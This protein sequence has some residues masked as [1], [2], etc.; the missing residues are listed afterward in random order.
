VIE[1]P[2]KT[3]STG[4]AV[5]A[6]KLF[7]RDLRTYRAML[8]ARRVDEA[9]AQFIRNR[10]AFF[11]VSGAGHE[12]SAVLAE[13]LSPSDWL[14]L[15]Y[16][17]KA[18]M[19]ARGIPPVMF[20]HS[21][22]CSAES[23]S[24]GRQMS[25]HMSDPALHILSLVG[26]V[27]NNALQ[28]VGVAAEVSAPVDSPIVVCSVGDGTSQQG[29]FMEAVAEAVREQL[30]VLFVIEDNAYAISTETSRKTWYSLRDGDPDEFYGLPIHRIDG[31]SPERCGEPLQACVTQLRSGC[32]P[33][34]VVMS[35]DRL[36]SHTNAD[37]EHVYRSHGE[38]GRVREEGDPLV[39][40]RRHL[41]ASGVSVARLDALERETAA[42][43]E[44]ARESVLRATAPSTNVALIDAPC[45]KPEARGRGEP[46]A[47]MSRAIRDVLG[48]HLMS[49]P[50][51]TLFGQDIEDP[52]GDV[53]GVTKGL[54][55][56]FKGRVVNSPLSESTIVGKAIG[57]A[58]AG[59][60]PVACIQF[61]DFLPLAFN[62]II[63][64]LG[65]MV[66]RTNG[67]WNC[68]V[69]IM[70]PCGGYRP[71]LGPFH[72]QTM[73]S[74]LSHVPDVQ[75][76]MPSNATDAAGLL[77]AAFESPRPTIFLYPKVCL[78][79]RDRTT[80]ADVS[81]QFVPLGRSRHLCRGDDLSIVTYG[82]TTYQC[83]QAAEALE[84]HGV[85]VDL[86]DLRS[87]KPWDT[88]AVIESAKRTGRL[89]VVH[90]DNGSCSVASEIVATVTESIT[91]PIQVRR[92]TRSDTYIP[93]D[94]GSQLE[95][96]PSFKRVLETATDL[97]GMEVGW[98]SESCPDGSVINIEAQGGSP[99]D[100]A[101]TLIEWRVKPGEVVRDGQV[102]VEL[103]AD[104][105]MFEYSSPYDAMVEELL[106]EPGV[107]VGVGTPI[108]RLR[109]ID[110]ERL[111]RVT[112]REESGRPVLKGRPTPAKMVR[113]AFAPA[114]VA[115]TM[116]VSVEGER[117]LTNEQIVNGFSERSAEEIFRLTGIHSRRWVGATQT[118][119][120]LAVDACDLALRREGLTISDINALVVSTTTPLS[121]TPS[122]ACLVLGELSSGEHEIPAHD[123]SAACTGYLY[124]LA[125]GY[126]FIQGR[127]DAR[128][129]VVTTEVLSPLLDPN[130]FDTAILFADA[131]TATILGGS[132]GQG[133]HLG[134]LHRP[135]LFSRP[136]TQGALRVGFRDRRAS[137]RSNGNG[138]PKHPA[139]VV[140]MDHGKRV[141]AQAVR[142]MDRALARA[143]DAAGYAPSD[144]SIV[145]PHQANGRIIDAVSG[146]LGSDCQVINA[147]AQSGNTS[148][149]SIPLAM[150]E[151]H[152]D[153]AATIGLCAFGGGFTYGAAIIEARR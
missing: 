10:Q 54:S 64:E 12:A 91:T 110:P 68:P 13:L 123:V 61:A 80:P 127:Q 109:L 7:S 77:N 113:Q 82:G 52:K 17:D 11:H 98:L 22:L 153:D 55:N 35:V 139:L 67:G 19:L 140:E 69:I 108:L 81:A 5:D 106:V 31:R 117:V 83:I 62:Q 137:Q 42:A 151:M 105:A 36:S 125:A 16:R 148:S 103:E 135:L 27:G 41:L 56:E 143:S 90:E 84:E 142:S 60:R 2:N 50:R 112:I 43:V 18:L 47:T 49:D 122:M 133:K 1:V 119:L 70:A 37:D 38:L 9:E 63:S 92:V 150:R 48:H 111:R 79:D 144:L 129:L 134:Q 136:D 104:K 32:G 71:G 53:F 89:I 8:L 124:A 141:F 15:H 95:V 118:A 101:V 100:Q 97:L 73:E 30:P 74:I 76:V 65:S 147:I 40:F 120:T 78:N 59:G 66:W 3:G 25:A 121:M 107:E 72:A 34:L 6:E 131:A 149:S 33:A 39:N 115:M 26:P 114:T 99:A 88:H 51:V 130:D 128:V 45:D 58:L 28:A 116:P 75:V 4:G 44:D 126:D 85:G 96:L 20:L 14:H 46:V 145:V 86:I 146:K 102:L 152:V 23:H 57:R 132:P 24:A 87:I 29:E 93:C 94:F 21:L 138:Q